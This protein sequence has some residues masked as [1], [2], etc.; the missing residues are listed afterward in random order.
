MSTLLEAEEHTLDERPAHT[1]AMCFRIHEDPPNGARRGIN[2]F[3]ACTTDHGAVYVRN[4]VTSGIV[5][6]GGKVRAFVGCE[7][8]G[9]V[10]VEHLQEAV[11]VGR[12]IGLKS[13]VRH[14]LVHLMQRFPRVLASTLRTRGRF[15]RVGPALVLTALASVM[16]SAGGNAQRVPERA[17]LSTEE[18]PRPIRPVHDLAGAIVDF[19]R[20]GWAAVSAPARLD[21]GGWARVGI[22]GAT[23]GTLFMLDDEI[24]G[25][26]KGGEP[27]GFH[28]GLRDV[29]DFFEPLGLMGNT[30]AYY[31]G[32]ATL[33]YFARQ[34][35]L[36]LLF[37]ELLYAHWIAGATR[38]AVG[39]VVGRARP[40][41]SPDDAYVFDPGSGRSFPSGHSSTI[42]QLA[43]ILAH[44]LDRT[45]A[46]V[47]LYGLASTVVFQRVDADEHWASD[48]FVG[49]AWGLAVAEI[50]IRREEDGRLMSGLEVSAHPVP[51]GLQV[52]LRLPLG[53]GS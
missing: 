50:V 13:D 43:H 27:S 19:G 35:R 28:S 46:S 47:V 31:A 34:E 38:Q 1:K 26:L 11:P 20:D 5:Q 42:M 49:A 23:A 21:G 22:V 52:A 8:T 24:R 37:K 4:L 25:S 41:N 7:R 32:A 33:A 48:A 53:P 6:I 51:G 9:T 39:R 16:S 3:Q 15:R 44:H 36:Q 12:G 10:A 30:N 40:R 17:G 14:V 18:T 2:C 29:G 45:P